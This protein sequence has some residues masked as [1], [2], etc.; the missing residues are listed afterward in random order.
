[1]INS[2]NGTSSAISMMMLSGS[3]QRQPPPPEKDLF[4]VSDTDGDGQVSEAELGSL[5]E[6]INQV[7]GSS[8][9]AA[10]ALSSSD[11]DQDGYLSSEE[12]LGMMTQNGFSS[13]GMTGTESGESRQPPPPPPVGQAM[14]SYAQNAEEDTL[15][16]L[17]ELLQGDEDDTEGVYTPVNVTT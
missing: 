1:M 8:L 5:V 14:S 15:A 9:T 13:P 16:E 6:G 3:M 4:Q 10:D 7:T 12:L 2:I 17:L 11:A